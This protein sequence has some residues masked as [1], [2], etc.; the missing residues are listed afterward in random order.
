MDGIVLDADL[1]VRLA[2]RA[3]YET[4][5]VLPAETEQRLVYTLGNSQWNI[6]RLRHLLEEILPQSTHFD[7]F[8]IEHTLPTI[9]R[10]SM[11][12]NARRV[13][14]DTDRPPHSLAVRA[15]LGKFSSAVRLTERVLGSEWARW[16]RESDAAMAS[17]LT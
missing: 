14:F 3:F 12:L 5:R 10:R 8:D 17:E 11:L 15:C 7:G 9:G 6:P 13:R 2:N 16:R 1:R 4:F